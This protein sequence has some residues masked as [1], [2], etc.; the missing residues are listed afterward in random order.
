MQSHYTQ[1]TKQQ[2]LDQYHTLKSQDMKEI[3]SRNLE[4]ALHM[5][6]LL[7]TLQNQYQY[8]NKDEFYFAYEATAARYFN[9]EHYY[10]AAIYYQKIIHLLLQHQPLSDYDYRNLAGKYIDLMDA[11]LA[12]DNTQAALYALH[13]AVITHKCIKF[14]TSKEAVF[15]QPTF[16]IIQFRLHYENDTSLPNYIN[17][18]EYQYQNFIILKIYQEYFMQCLSDDML[19]CQLSKTSNLCDRIAQKKMLP[20]HYVELTNYYLQLIEDYI[21]KIQQIF[22]TPQQIDYLTK[23][24]EALMHAMKACAYLS[25]TQ[26]DKLRLES[27]IQ[28]LRQQLHTNAAS[29]IKTHTVFN[30]IPVTPENEK[31]EVDNSSQGNQLSHG[32]VF[33]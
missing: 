19:E 23:C 7:E 27:R 11:N 15:I 31:M 4:R 1:H 22:N 24:N 14:H 32:Q 8:Y 16:D 25:T 9:I 21:K 29:L 33:H 20:E 5:I 18:N 12:L 6:T 30:T 17:S 28:Q 3:Q 13:K 2:L 26:P 10:H